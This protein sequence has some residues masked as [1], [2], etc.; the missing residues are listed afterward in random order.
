MDLLSERGQVTAAGLRD[1]L[2]T[3]EQVF[4]RLA[5]EIAAKAAEQGRTVRAV[6]ADEEKGVRERLEGMT[7]ATKAAVDDLTT[8]SQAAGDQLRQA[9]RA[10]EKAF[11]R[12]AEELVG[13]A[14]AI[15]DAT[16]RQSEALDQAAQ[17]AADRSGTLAAI[18]AERAEDMGRA[19]E[20]AAQDV[21]RVG[22]AFSTETARLT[23]VARAGVAEAVS[24]RDALTSLRSE[25]ATAAREAAERI[26]GIATLLRQQVQ[27]LTRSAETVR[28]DVSGA[29]AALGDHTHTFNKALEAAGRKAGEIA[30]VF[31]AQANAL[32][33]A[34]ENAT[35]EA[36]KI[37]SGSLDAKRDT[38]LRASKLVMESLTS[39]GIDLAR[40]VDR[41]EAEKLWRG[42]SRGDKTLFIRSLLSG[43]EKKSMLAIKKRY[44]EDDTFRRHVTRYVEDFERLLAQANEADPDNLLSSAFVPSDLGRLYVALSRAI[45]RMH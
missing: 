45:G 11:E 8:G 31:A 14:K 24:G 40:L 12:L 43:G 3:E 30:D 7:A 2:A 17:A 4:R 33:E 27:E 19:T 6:I 38:F 10:E 21:A 35:K 32:T 29:G 23:E 39:Q 41:E 15:E 42:Y 25:L 28:T 18:L 26:H 16:A 34:S 36:S 5:E 44:E 9:V 37:R 22:E 1:V 20:R 13:R